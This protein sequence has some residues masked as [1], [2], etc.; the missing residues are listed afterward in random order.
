MIDTTVN[1]IMAGRAF[2]VKIQVDIHAV[3]IFLNSILS[4]FFYCEFSFLSGVVEMFEF[5]LFLLI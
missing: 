4:K 5:Q 3:C 2:C 1:P